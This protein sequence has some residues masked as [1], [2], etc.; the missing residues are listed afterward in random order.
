MTHGVTHS[1]MAGMG[2]I[3]SLESLGS[4]GLLSL[5]LYK[6]SSSDTD[7]EI[8]EEIERAGNVFK[9]GYEIWGALVDIDEDELHSEPE[10]FEDAIDKIQESEALQ[11]NL[12]GLEPIP[13][14]DQLLLG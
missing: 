14:P 8:R 1:A 2:K 10:D 9:E 12:S 13:G 4:Q 7:E 5:S 6:K 3:T 11:K